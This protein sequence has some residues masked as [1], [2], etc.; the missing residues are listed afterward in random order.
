LLPPPDLAPLAPPNLLSPPTSHLAPPSLPPHSHLLTSHLHHLPPPTSLPHTCS[1]PRNAFRDVGDNSFYDS[2]LT[3]TAQSDLAAGTV[4]TQSDFG[5]LRLSNTAD[6]VL[7]YTGSRA[8]PNFISALDN[9]K[10]YNSYQCDEDLTIGFQAV[11]CSPDIGYT[12]F[13]ELPPV[14]RPP[15]QPHQHRSP[16]SIRRALFSQRVHTTVHT[17]RAGSC[18]RG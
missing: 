18:G 6:Q 17:S 5:T 10:G 4:L 15:H 7:V 3:Y 8:S 16:R 2:H 9:S 14:C 12:H 1:L 11:T 13:S